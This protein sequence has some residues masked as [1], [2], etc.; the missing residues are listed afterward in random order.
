MFRSLL[1]GGLLLRTIAKEL[2][3]IRLQLTRQTDLLERLATLYIP[4]QAETTAATSRETGVSYL[5]PV[6]AGLVM[7][8]VERTT[9]DTGRAPSEDEIL[10]F[11]ADEKTVDL[12]TRIHDR[13]AREL[14]RLGGTE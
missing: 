2:G 5:D 12:Q 9:Q 4:P 1:R 3:G 6:E 11:L 7:D 10:T 14:E 8:Y 13:A